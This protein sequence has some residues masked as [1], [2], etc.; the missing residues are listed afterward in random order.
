MTRVVI[1]SWAS[2][3]F[4]SAS[5]AS[6]RPSATAWSIRS[7]AF[8]TIRSTTAL[9]ST[10]F[11]V[12]TSASVP[13]LRSQSPSASTSTPIEGGNFLHRLL[14]VLAPVL[15]AL[16][17]GPVLIGGFVDGRVVGLGV[18]DAADLGGTQDRAAGQRGGQQA[19][20]DPLVREVL[21]GGCSLLLRKIG[22]LMDAMK[23]RDGQRSG[24]E[25]ERFGKDPT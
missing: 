7:F 4:P 6:I 20:L 14:A 18:H 8:A 12:A 13:P 15:A 2:A 9:G 5:V 25:T 24:W 1:R 10:P 23:R 22:G 16:L 19:G 3:F 11:S 17:A 21:H